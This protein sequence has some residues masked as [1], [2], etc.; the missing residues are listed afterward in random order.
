VLVISWKGEPVKGHAVN[1]AGIMLLLREGRVD[2]VESLEAAVEGSIP[3]L[4]PMLD[5]LKEAGL[6]ETDPASPV[7]WTGAKVRLGTKFRQIQH[8]LRFSLHDLSM[9]TADTLAVQP[10]FGRPPPLSDPLD[11]FV[12]MPFA[13]DLEDVYRDHITR[14]TSALGLVAKRGDDFFSAHHVMSDIWRAIWYSQV[15][16]A[17]CTTKNPNVFYEI[18]V[19]HAIG[20]PVVLITQ[21]DDD[22]PFDLR[23]TRYIKYEFKPRGMEIFES[24]LKSTIQTILIEQQPTSP[25]I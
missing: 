4:E 15:I 21:N 5:G 24:R 25:Y 16:V 13:A 18:G 12:L 17:D 2:D 8:M 10:Y 3:Y 14:V 20:R 6:I 7:D 1:P 19:A 23:S 9:S 22:V 11:V